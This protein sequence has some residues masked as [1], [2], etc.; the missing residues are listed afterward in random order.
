MAVLSALRLA[1]ATVS[2]GV[3]GH[4]VLAALAT[5]ALARLALAVAAGPA[6]YWAPLAVATALAIGA[7]LTVVLLQPPWP[8]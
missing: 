1:G 5:N 7:G 8:R 4:A 3:I 2:I 6:R